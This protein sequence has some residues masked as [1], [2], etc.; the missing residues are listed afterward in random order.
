MSQNVYAFAQGH[1]GMRTLLGGKGANLAE[2]CRLGLPVPQGFT[3]TTQA[4]LDY[5]KH[6]ESGLSPE[7]KA[8]IQAAIQN[9]EAQ[10]QKEFNGPDRLLLVSVRSGAKISMPGM[11]DTIL[12]VGLNDVN[13]EVLA[14]ISDNPHFAYDCYRRLLQMY[15]DVVYG[16]DSQIFEERLRQARHQEGVSAD[17][18]L[19]VQ[20]L[21]SLVEDFK[22]IYLQELGFDF[23]QDVHQQIY[24][25]VE[26]VFKSWN[27]KR[28]QVYRQLHDIPDD[29]GTAV[30]IQ[31]MVFGNLGPNSGTGVLF[32]RHPATGDKAL[33]GEFLVNAQG[34][35]V[36]AGIRTPQSLSEI[37]Q[38]SPSLYQEI[39]ELAQQL[40][41]HY[42]DMQDIEFTIE[43]GKLYFL[44]TRNG[45][46][47]A[48]AAVKIAVDLVREGVISK[49]EALQQVD[50]KSLDQMLH[51]SFSAENLS[52]AELLSEA[53]LA[54]SPGAASGAIVFTA[55][56]ATAWAQAGKACILVRQE[57]SPE[58]IEGMTAAQA[59]LTCH[60][61]MTSHAAVVARGM[62]KC[63]VTGCHDLTVDEAQGRLHCGPVTLEEG[64]QISVDGNTGRVYLGQVPTS[65]SKAGADFDCLMAWAREESRL[66][67]RMNA[68]TPQD[69]QTGFDFKAQGIGLV[70]TEH[71]FF[72]TERLREIRRFILSSKASDRQAALDQIAGYQE[73]DFKAIFDLSQGQKT[74]IRLLDPP[75]HEF[76]P[77]AGH[78]IQSVAQSL[79]LSEDKL[80]ARIQQL[81]EVNPMLGHRG[82][83]LAMTCPELYDMQVHAILAGALASQ[84]ASGYDLQ[85]EI[86]IPLVSLEKELKTLKERLEKTAAAYL[87]EEQMTL[88]YKI[89]T[90]IEIPRACLTADQIA[91]EADFI[92]FGTNDLTQMTFG[93]SRDDAGKFIHQYLADGTLSKDPFQSLDQE[94]VGAL[95]ELACQK[96][97]SIKADIPIGVCGEVAGDP[98]SIAFFDAIGLD[99]ISCSPF[100][101]PIAQLAAAQAN[102]TNRPKTA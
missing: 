31:E 76:L 74:V 73:A 36:V 18:E 38:K 63:C 1:A 32:T 53:G 16:L 28:A 97:R 68:E 42:R 13:V 57:T 35:D 21:K 9:L 7:L 72:Q 27:N 92:S 71:M 52:Q 48:K 8:D 75:L 47:T 95:M 2:L 12:N 5:L 45:K 78:E 19:S 100:R 50:A 11:M 34:E 20:A 77:Q 64:D 79:G 49:A 51:P 62:G 93:Y 59:I 41:A 80:R 82:C 44:Q 37:A 61:G 10:S 87:A 24:D 102:L 84:K 40:E 91:Q 56:Q 6:S 58:D 30:N 3:I 14:Q 96:A 67:V 98:A 86:M 25:A 22:A 65:P 54:A 17:Y 89:G 81:K 23:P 60:G 39:E 33:F 90:M 83:R 15:A 70:R 43:E 66:A 85:V 29:L 4:C 94:G 88:S 69:I 46:R 101:L 55:D 26:A 99:Y